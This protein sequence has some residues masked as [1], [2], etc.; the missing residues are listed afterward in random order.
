MDLRNKRVLVTG[1]SGFIGSHLVEELIR[2]GAIVKC[3]VHYNGR[4]DWGNLEQASDSVKTN[5]E[6][7][8]GDVQDPFFVRKMV[9]GCDVVFHLA[10]LIAIPYSYVAPQSYVS[11]NIAGTLNVLQSCLDEK[12]TKVIHTSTSEVFGSAI[13]TPIDEKHPLQGQS[14]YSASKISA[15]KLAESFYRSFDLPVATMRPFN[16]FGPRQSAR[17]IVP[18]IISQALTKKEIELGSLTPVRD[19]TFVK[20]TVNAFIRMAECDESTGQEI[21]IGTGV[22]VTIGELAD[23]II[24][25]TG[26]SC[27]IITKKERM[28]PEKSEVIKLICDPSKARKLLEWET[29]HTLE[30]GLIETID[31]VS[32][33]IQFFKNQYTI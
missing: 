14:P 4:N 24:K 17:A 15:D 13:Y 5:I 27:T 2:K 8:L 32:R 18:T 3:L 19:L 9:A 29:Q 23:L 26:N 16:T 1:A 21:N 20:D 25:L 22:G 12:V 28:R 33:N 30:V 11:T 6:V 7:I 31:F 10:A